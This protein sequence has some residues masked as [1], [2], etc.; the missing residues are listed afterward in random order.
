MKIDL[1]YV[2][3]KGRCLQK[4]LRLPEKTTILEALHASGW[5]NEAVFADFAKWLND[6]PPD[7]T[8]NHKA[9]FVGVFSQKKALNSVLCDGDR[10][11]IYRPLRLNPM[12]KRG[13]KS[14]AARQQFSQKS[15][16]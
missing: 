12:Q 3:P 16:E 1:I 4:T 15:S 11:E 2:D 5:L 14:G 7:Q 9:W 8:P 13:L 10:L 6:T